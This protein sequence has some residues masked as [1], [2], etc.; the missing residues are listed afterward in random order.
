MLPLAFLPYQRECNS[1]FIVRNFDTCAVR[2]IVYFFTSISSR[3]I[4]RE[5]KPDE[6]KRMVFAEVKENKA[7]STHFAYCLR[8]KYREKLLFT[9]DSVQKLLSDLQVWANHITFTS[10]THKHHTYYL[11]NF[12]SFLLFLCWTFSSIFWLSRLSNKIIQWI[13]TIFSCICLF[14]LLIVDS[15]F[16]HFLHSNETFAFIGF[17]LIHFC[18]SDFPFFHSE[19]TANFHLDSPWNDSHNSRSCYFEC[20]PLLQLQRAALHCRSTRTI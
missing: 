1:F 12:H 7:I 13:K 16:Y 6:K 2:N 17:F 8:W 20:T 19:H 14:R 9:W 4:R 11:F 5:W 18:S 15:L 3:I 10:I